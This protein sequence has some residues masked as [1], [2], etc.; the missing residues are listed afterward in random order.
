MTWE[1]LLGLLLLLV[2]F[3]QKLANVAVVEIEIGELAAHVD[4]LRPL[5]VLGVTLGELEENLLALALLVAGDVLERFL[6]VPLCEPPV[7][8]RLEGEAE[9]HQ[10]PPEVPRVL[11]RCLQLGDRLV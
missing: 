3:V 1:E 5:A 2:P 4:R 6:E 11:A 8:P 10:R 7:L 9:E